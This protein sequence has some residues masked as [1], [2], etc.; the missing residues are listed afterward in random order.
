VETIAAGSAA[1]EELR[2]RYFGWDISVERHGAIGDA[3][4]FLARKE[5]VAS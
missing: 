2:S 1:I 4:I 5:Q 3:Q